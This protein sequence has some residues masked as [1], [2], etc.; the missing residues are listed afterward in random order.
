M[1]SRAPPSAM[2]V[3]GKPFAKYGEAFPVV[4]GKNGMGWGKG[5]SSVER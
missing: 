2:N 4:V 5:L 1:T 3:T